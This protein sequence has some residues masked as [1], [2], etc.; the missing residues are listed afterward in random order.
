VVD[1]EET[2]LIDELLEEELDAEFDADE[3]GLDPEEE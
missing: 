2:E 1:R 3:M